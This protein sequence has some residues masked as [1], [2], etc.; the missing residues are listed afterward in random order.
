MAGFNLKYSYCI[1]INSNNSDKRKEGHLRMDQDV[2]ISGSAETF[3]QEEVWKFD[4]LVLS[5]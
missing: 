3:P 5:Y 1:C 4:T 2:E